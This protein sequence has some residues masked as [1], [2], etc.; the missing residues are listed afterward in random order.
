MKH[1]IQLIK[2][3]SSE[4][5]NLELETDFH[6]KGFVLRV[7]DEEYLVTAEDIIALASAI[8]GVAEWRKHQLQLR[9][10]SQ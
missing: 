8:T 10:G 7:D 9:A 3:G 4:M 1:T 2:R 6:Y 5:S